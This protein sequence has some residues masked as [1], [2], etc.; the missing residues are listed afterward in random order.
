MPKIGN[1]VVYAEVVR[2]PAM[3]IGTLIA[4]GTPD[5]QIKPNS[6]LI[7]AD[8]TKFSEYLLKIQK[9]KQIKNLVNYGGPKIEMHDDGMGIDLKANDGIYTGIFK[10]TQYEGNY[11][12]IFRAK[13][14]NRDGIVFDRAKTLSE[15][16]KFSVDPKKTDVKAMSTTQDKKNKIN[17]TTLRITP[18]SLTGDYLGPFRAE[19]IQ[20]STNSGVYVND[21]VD[22]MDGSYKMALTYPIESDPDIMILVDNVII[23]D[24]DGNVLRSVR[25]LSMEIEKRPDTKLIVMSVFLLLMLLFILYRFLIHH[26]A[27]KLI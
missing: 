21:I 5:P 20:L 23:P 3:S 15:Y 7:V 13:G 12:F 4:E 25:K 26:K 11:T 10:N 1:T 6:S 8:Q 18:R 17:V 2:S 9:Q 19:R 16:V 24:S 14:Q 27:K 22:N